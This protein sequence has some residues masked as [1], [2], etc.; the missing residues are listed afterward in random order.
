VK[1]QRLYA[2]HLRI[3]WDQPAQFTGQVWL[4]DKPIPKADRDESRADC[5]TIPFVGLCGESYAALERF[6]PGEGLACRQWLIWQDAPGDDAFYVGDPRFPADGVWCQS[7]KATIRHLVKAWPLRL[8][9]GVHEHE[10][11]E[12]G[13]DQPEALPEAPRGV[14]VPIQRT[15]AEILAAI[16]EKERASDPK[17]SPSRY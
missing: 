11:D 9:G 16:R 12:G 6:M 3:E 8:R 10:Q 15:A 14:V 1:P 7:A 2:K 17:A 5:E 4:L 13:P